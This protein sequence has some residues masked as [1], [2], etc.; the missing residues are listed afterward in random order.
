MGLG[1]ALAGALL[2]AR[3]PA[4]ALLYGAAFVAT[5]VWALVERF[6]ASC[7]NGTGSD[8][9]ASQRA[10]TPDVLRYLMDPS[11]HGVDLLA[12]PG[13]GRSTPCVDESE[14]TG[15]CFCFCF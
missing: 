8:P 11:T 2:L 10:L 5:A 15:F 4:G 9:V 12:V 7:R 6:P 13:T 14:A 1:S 3:R